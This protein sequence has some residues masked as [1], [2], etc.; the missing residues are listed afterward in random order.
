[1]LSS[2][3]IFEKQLGSRSEL[4]R[5]VTW[6]KLKFGESAPSSLGRSVS[7][8]ELGPLRYCYECV[9]LYDTI[10]KFLE[11]SL[12][13]LEG[14]LAFSTAKIRILPCIGDILLGAFI[15]FRSVSHQMFI[16]GGCMSKNL[17]A[18]ISVYIR[19]MNFQVLPLLPP[20]IFCEAMSR[21]E[22][23]S[24]FLFSCRRILISLTNA[25]T[26]QQ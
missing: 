13:F 21:F 5:I 14:S 4:I 9:H 7:H 2:Q 23:F 3:I 11:G 19:R 20:V 22:M 10:E 17:Q 25:R 6:I 1:M 15:F 18:R 16:F 24:R 8:L 12:K 26:H